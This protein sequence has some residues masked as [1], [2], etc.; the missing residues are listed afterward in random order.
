MARKNMQRVLEAWEQGRGAVGDSK[1]T[2]WTDGETVWSYDMPIM[3]RLG[4][5][6]VEVIARKQ[7]P[8]NTTRSQIAACAQFCDYAKEVDCLTGRK[9]HVFRDRA[10]RDGHLGRTGRRS[11]KP[12]TYAT[13]RFEA[14]INPHRPAGTFGSVCRHCGE[15]IYADAHTP[16]LK[17]VR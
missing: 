4:D 2:C 15:G 6:R 3:Q 16:Q 7:G 1:R 11:P 14:E 17:V 5:G 12:D 10:G 13:H 9:P 8:T